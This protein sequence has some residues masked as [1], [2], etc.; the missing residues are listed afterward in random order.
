MPKA[1]INTSLSALIN[2]QTGNIFCLLMALL[3]VS[4]FF[5]YLHFFNWQIS[6]DDAFNFVRAV[7]RFSV[8]EFRPHFPGYPGFI[9]AIHL[10]TFFYDTSLQA[11]IAYTSSSILSMAL[12]CAYLVYLLTKSLPMMLLS[13]SCFIVCPLLLGLSLSGLS[14]APALMLL[15]AGLL[16]VYKR[17]AF[18]MGGAIALMLATRP[19]YL[20]FAI[21]FLLFIPLFENKKQALL[22]AIIP[23]LLTGLLCFLFLMSKDGVSYFYEGFRFTQGHFLIWGNTSAA[24]EQSSV[25]AWFTRIIHL[26]GWQGAF[27]LV[28][29]LFVSLLDKAYF[30]KALAIL[31]I[32]YLLYILVAQNPD[33]IRHFAPVYCLFLTLF[34]T[35]LHKLKA[36]MGDKVSHK[37]SHKVSYKVM[38]GLLMVLILLPY[39]SFYQTQALKQDPTNQAI[40]YLQEVASYNSSLS[41]SGNN[42]LGNNPMI[43][44]TNYS[45]NWIK[46]QLKSVVVLDSYYPSS[47]GIITNALAWRLSGSSLSSGDYQLIKTF[48]KR[49]PTE[50]TLYLYRV[51]DSSKD[52]ERR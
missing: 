41:H 7:E 30:I 42:A 34:F 3:A 35:Q 22:I 5:Y 52:K 4:V 46:D 47:E 36:K 17:Q 48:N 11:L 37:M 27:L 16:F 2:K 32:V 25:L 29:T 26:M 24:Q 40:H 23:I 43:L 12:L 18:L 20:P 49:L 21:S 8:L 19:S 44:A 31:T 38:C 33:N 15:C 6:T 14:D 9:A 1:L 45:V 10:F 28:I 51:I 50:R 13:F 39:L